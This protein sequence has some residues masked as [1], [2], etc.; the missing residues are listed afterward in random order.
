MNIENKDNINKTTIQNYIT[1]IIHDSNVFEGVDS[2]S[3]ISS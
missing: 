2:S 1:D 3:S